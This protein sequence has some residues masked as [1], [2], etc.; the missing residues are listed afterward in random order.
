MPL[1][2]LKAALRLSWA[3]QCHSCHGLESTSTGTF[4]QAHRAG[5]RAG[6]WMESRKQLRAP[7][8]P[9]HHAVESTRVLPGMGHSDPSSQK[10]PLS[11]PL[12]SWENACQWSTE[13]GM[14]AWIPPLLPTLMCSCILPPGICALCKVAPEAIKSG[15]EFPAASLRFYQPRG[16][17]QNSWPE[18][19]AV[20]LCLHRK[21]HPVASLQWVTHCR[22]GTGEASALC[23]TL[24]TTFW[25][26]PK[27]QSC[28][29]LDTGLQPAKHRTNPSSEWPPQPG[30]WITPGEKKIKKK[31][32]VK[33]WKRKICIMWCNARADWTVPPRVLMAG[34]STHSKARSVCAA[35]AGGAALA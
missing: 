9:S 15:E 30:I 33:I 32:P 8:P 29:K 23:R 12:I 16:E 17:K 22:T 31:K 7:C 26:G 18:G 13:P 1:S 21:P 20:L 2:A 25:L 35:H 27:A 11:P 24:H 10:I 34:V 3:L 4:L 28:L 19:A 14:W 6:M 5:C